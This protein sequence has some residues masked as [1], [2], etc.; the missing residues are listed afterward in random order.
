MAS[1]RL[2]L[3]GLSTLSP[4]GASEKEVDQVVSRP[5]NRAVP[6][7]EHRGQPVFPLTASG[8]EIVD[9][10]SK[11]ER[12]SKVDRVTHL[13]IASARQTLSSDALAGLP[14][15]LV[16]IGSSR[17]A[18]ITLERTIR[19]CSSESPK[20]PTYTSPI[21]TAGNISSWVAQEYLAGSGRQDDSVAALNTSMTCSSAF[22]SLLAALAFVRGGMAE[23]ALFGG[24]E[25]CLTPYTIAHL[26]ALRI[27]SEL[28]TEWPCR[29]GNEE[30]LSTV[31]LGE[32]AGTAVLSRA[33]GSH[34][35]RDLELLGIG[36]S[37]EEAPTA[38]GVSADGASFEAAMRRAIASMPAGRAVDCVVA[39]AP[40]SI[41]GDDAELS[42]ISR[43]FGG[44]MTVST[45]HLTGHTYGASGMVSLSVAQSLL[46]GVTWPGFPYKCR[47]FSEL[48]GQPGAVLINTAGFGGNCI[49]IVV[50]RP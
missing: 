15:G 16:S 45:K 37:I 39:H 24:A 22:H 1:D 18:T 49:S 32:G 31:V 23:A 8:A 43:V 7:K 14:L 9:A 30:S 46:Y 20:V 27:Y 3:K 11:E 50:G 33:K 38:T 42:A 48:L 26:D 29:P 21:T 2:F 13:A 44:V 5:E 4:L 6:F 17:G 34:S 40:G 36:W 12:F 47:F 25:A 41:K 35:S 10:I 28:G 19:E